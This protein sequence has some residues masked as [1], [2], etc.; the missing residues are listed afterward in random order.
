[1]GRT[2]RQCLPE[3]SMRVLMRKPAGCAVCS[4]S[5]IERSRCASE[6]L[7]MALPARLM[8][9]ATL[10]RTEIGWPAFQTAR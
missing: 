3:R 8:A 2:H 4:N 7:P 6:T 1:M 9:G 10:W 5:S